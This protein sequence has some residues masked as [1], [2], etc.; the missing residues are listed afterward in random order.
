MHFATFYCPF[1]SDNF[2]FV[3][4]KKL[5]FFQLDDCL[6]IFPLLCRY[7]QFEECLTDWKEFWVDEAYWHIL[8]AILLLVI[9][10]LWR[11]SNNNQVSG[12]MD[13]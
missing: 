6:H 11:P 8:F 13:G 3:Y 2:L 7:H 10:I 5:F 1:I 12:W 9:M 4:H